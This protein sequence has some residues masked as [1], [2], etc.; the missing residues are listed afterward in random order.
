MQNGLTLRDNRRLPLH[1]PSPPVSE[2]SRVES[3]AAPPRSVGGLA[4]KVLAWGV[5]VLLLGWLL[6]RTPLE[7]AQAALLRPS[8]QT[9]ALTVA[10]LLLSYGLRAA[11][12]QVVL[13]LEGHSRAPRKWLGLRT[14]ALRV[15]LMHNAAIN[16]L[17]MRAGELSFPWLAS[18]ELGMPVA[19]AIA[20]LLWMRLQDVMV[21][22]V[23]GA[24]LWPGVPLWL[25]LVGLLALVLGWTLATALMRRWFA[26]HPQEAPAQEGRIGAMLRKLQHAV[27]EPSHHH[28]LAW[29]ATFGNWMVKLA[30]GAC[31]LSAISA[32]PWPTA[33]AGA[34]GGELAAI[35][36]LQGPAG[37]GTYEAGV[38]AGMATQLPAKSAALAQAVSAA[39]ALHACF[40]LCAVLAGLVATLLSTRSGRPRQGAAPSSRHPG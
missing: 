28:P 36:P 7:Q 31:L 24:L 2:P 30:A 10:G 16:L 17:P 3:G 19:R 18:R 34:L 12:L 32:A 13:D 9:W 40:L 11:R 14:D 8:W 4:K 15:I 5:G 26:G 29:L 33:W 20:C 35:V 21:L 37:F 22:A 39:L 6:S 23:L 1:L 38:W 27:L 25:R